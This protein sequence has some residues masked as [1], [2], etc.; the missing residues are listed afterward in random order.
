MEILTDIRFD[1]GLDEVL[2][3]LRVPAGGDDARAVAS[4]LA[5][6]RERARPKAGYD[7]C[8][9][10]ERTSNTVTIGGVVFTSRV[11]RVNLDEVH[12]VFP[13]VATCGVELDEI[14]A[15]DPLARYWLEEIKVMAVS[16]A[17]ARLREHLDETFRPGKMSAMAPGSLADWPITQQRPLFALL[18]E[19][20]ARLGVRL[21]ED[22]LMVP[23]KS[24]S[25]IY[26]PTET[27][28]ESC[29]LCP[30]PD[31]PGRRAAYDKTLWQRRYAERPSRR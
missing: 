26:F 27:S 30:R 28:F 31:C 12:R 29:R 10:G 4:L 22:C 21:T 5:M 18:G 9:V 6:A 11:L 3:R 8:Y 13:Y 17:M 24:V 16:A 15:P 19:V 1:P 7:V 14:E 25:G 2:A 23:V 20:E